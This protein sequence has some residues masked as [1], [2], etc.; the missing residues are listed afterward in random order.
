LKIPESESC[1]SLRLESMKSSSSSERHNE[2]EE[3]DDEG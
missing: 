3:E 2:V 1:L